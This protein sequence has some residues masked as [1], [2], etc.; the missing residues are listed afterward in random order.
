MS[1]DTGRPPTA[2]R[3]ARTP[4]GA[5]L[6]ST[7]AASSARRAAPKRGRREADAPLPLIV[8]GGIAGAVAAGVPLMALGFAT[9]SAWMLAPAA[10]LDAATMIETAGGAWLAGQGLSPVIQ[11]VSITLLPW[12]FGLI[13]MA[14][15]VAA[16]RW[17]AN[18]S[19][20]GRRGEALAVAGATAVT[21]GFIAGLVALVCR[22]LDVAPLRALLVCMMLAF[23]IAAFVSLRT[24]VPGA[25]RT[26][27]VLRDVM[28][29]AMAGTLLLLSAGAIAVAVSLLL[30]M[31]DVGL[32]LGRLQPDVAGAVLLTVLSLAYLPVVC[33]W[34]T[35]Y[36]LGPGFAIG[37][38]H[39][40]APLSDVPATTVP[41]LPLLAALPSEAPAF[42]I[43]LP[44][45][46]LLAGAAC[47]WLL[48]RRDR[49]G[50]A[51][52][53]LAAL[54][55]VV[56]GAAMALLG[57][58]ASGS[59][60]SARLADLGP[61]PLVLGLATTVLLLVG[62]LAVVVWPPRARAAVLEPVPDVAGG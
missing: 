38:G 19:S 23:V 2:A 29:A 48:R 10:D 11:G 4:D 27:P 57:L 1:L 59:L 35:A 22:N 49:V 58:L 30:H 36:L 21:Y 62:S 32:L 8:A 41:G 5:R 40:I 37:E 53:G 16:S 61:S 46:G 28:A 42:G 20:A 26:G 9:L 25:L 31:P 3:R 33:V 60:G 45:V 18:A 34:A 55:A 13:S 17:A 52:A 12:G 24:S 54:S 44:A 7:A 39:V 50:A 47:G 51:G 56:A 15:L 6:G 43:A 14:L